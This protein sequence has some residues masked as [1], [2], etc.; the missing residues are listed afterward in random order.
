MWSSHNVDSPYIVKNSSSC[1]HWMSRP[2]SVREIRYRWSWQRY[3]KKV[4]KLHIKK[5]RFVLIPLSDRCSQRTIVQVDG[6]SRERLRSLACAWIFLGRRRKRQKW[7]R[8]T[9]KVLRPK[10]YDATQLINEGSISH[11]SKGCVPASRCLRK[12][13][14]Q[15][16]K[17]SHDQYTHDVMDSTLVIE[18]PTCLVMRSQNLHL[19]GELHNSQERVRM[20]SIPVKV[21]YQVKGSKWR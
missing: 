10:K 14:L 4:L 13:P 8:K 19:V 12:A 7:T 3:T 5:T 11:L 18:R 16:H 17:T 21:P 15:M 1:S 9:Q 6:Q 20:C 2:L